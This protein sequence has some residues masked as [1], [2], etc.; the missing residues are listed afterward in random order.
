MSR[1]VLLLVLALSLIVG[2]Q[3]LK[4]WVVDH[5]ALGE[6]FSFWPGIMDLTYLQNRGAAF[7]ILQGQI[8]F[9]FLTTCL[10]MGVAAYYFVKAKPSQWGRQVGLALMMA[11]GIGNFMDRVSQGFV[12]DMFQLTFI[13]F[14]VFNLADSYLTVGVVIL[15]LD[16][17]REDEDG[18]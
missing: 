18:I 10:A 3:F 1:K 6:Q 9:F 11:G 16:L 2:D 14:A 13:D 15:I 12:V 8:W 5:I 17:L 7:S 4:S